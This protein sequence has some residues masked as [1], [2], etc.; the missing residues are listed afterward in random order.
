MKKIIFMGTPEFAKTVLEGLIEDTQYEIV[1]VVTQPDRPAGRKR[2]L[3][4][5]PVKELALQHDIPVHQPE[6][7]SGS[8]TVQTLIDLDA[9]LIVT[10]AY[11]QYVPTKL[12]NAPEFKAINVHASLLPKYRGGAPIH[13]A[14]WNG[15]DETGISLIYMT[16]E[17]DAGD[18]I[19]QETTP[20]S[21]T[22][23]VGDLF[24]RLAV[25][26]CDLL[27]EQLPHIFAETIQPWSQD[28]DQVTFSPTISRAQEQLQWNQT[29]QEID[30]HIRA[31][32]PFPST[33][34]WLDG[35]RTKIIQGYP[36]DQ[37][38][39]IDQLPGTIIEVTDDALIV[40]AGHDTA[41]CIKEWQPAGK[42]AMPIKAYLNGVDGEELIGQRFEVKESHEN[43]S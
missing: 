34:T 9:D 27:L 33:Y 40:Q 5:S 1:A 35:Q 15:D 31:F 38:S 39:T 7:L 2:V 22:D 32:R 21:S 11:G 18:I 41:Y 42:K 19:A 6:K 25:M 4:A 8:E 28:K 24:E 3:T 36:L 17:M 14:I 29:A 10:A 12:I 20:I 13:Y 16:K 26:G 43:K 23:D 30:Q 37:A